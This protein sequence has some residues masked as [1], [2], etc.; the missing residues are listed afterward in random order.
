[1]ALTAAV[2][3]T[4]CAYDPAKRD[5]NWAHTG[6]EEI[7]VP[8]SEA[9]EAAKDACA[10]ETGDSKI[11]GYWSGY[12]DRFMACMKARGWIRAGSPL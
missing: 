12:S 10:R 3:V 6:P 2:F 9:L 5:R 4:G 11:P 8:I 7:H 1:M